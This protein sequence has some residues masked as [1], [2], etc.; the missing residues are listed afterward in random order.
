[1]DGKL[2]EMRVQGS[3]LYAELLA[4]TVIQE[5]G[6]GKLARKAKASAMLGLFDFRGAKLVRT[7]CEE[8]RTCR[9]HLVILRAKPLPAAST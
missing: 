4:D 5:V 1:M 8:D 3:S 6:E 9:L 7:S 2:M